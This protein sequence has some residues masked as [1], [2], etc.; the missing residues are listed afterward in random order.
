M[1]VLDA[2]F[3]LRASLGSGVTRSSGSVVALGLGCT[4]GPRY[5]TLA[6]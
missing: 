4:S 5:T 2:D 6:A 1:S 3:H